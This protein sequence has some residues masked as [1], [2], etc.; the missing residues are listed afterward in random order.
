MLLASNAQDRERAVVEQRYQLDKATSRLGSE[1]YALS[2]HARQYLNTGDPTYLVIYRRDV[3][4][5]RSVEERIRH[6][7]DAGA[8]TEELNTLQEAVR[9]ADTLHDEQRTALEAYQRGDQAPRL[10]GTATHQSEG[11]SGGA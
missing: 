8:S 10:P 6:L 5:L 9:W 2:H 11:S 4:A 1:I 3:A 7:G